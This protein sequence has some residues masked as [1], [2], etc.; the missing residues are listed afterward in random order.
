VAVAGQDGAGTG[1]QPPAEGA[2]PLAPGGEGP[3]DGHVAGTSASFL[4]GPVIAFGIVGI[5]VLLLRWTFTTGSSVVAR[6]S[7][8]GAEDDYGLLVPVASP[9]TY[10]EGEIIR[11]TLE[12]DGIRATLTETLDGPRVMV[13]PADLER[14]REVV[15]RGR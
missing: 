6:R 8:S 12:G 14:A 3:D 2:R 1:S 7:R 15:S 9:S 4:V 13:F 11:R 5:L 10:I